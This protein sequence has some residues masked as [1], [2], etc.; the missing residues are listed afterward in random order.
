MNLTIPRATSDFLNWPWPVKLSKHWLHVAY[1]GQGLLRLSDF[2]Y[3]IDSTLI[4]LQQNF[5]LATTYYEDRLAAIVVDLRVSWVRDPLFLLFYWASSLL[6]GIN[7]E[8]ISS[9]ISCENHCPNGALYYHTRHK[10]LERRLSP[11]QPLLSHLYSKSKQIFLN[12][13]H[14]SKFSITS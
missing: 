7:A 9:S 12:P 11:T 1:N 5:L 13:N 3:Q 10:N 2:F 4:P 8:F 6:E 14:A